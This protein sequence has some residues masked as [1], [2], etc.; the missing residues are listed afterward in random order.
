MFL[1]VLALLHAP[2]CS[3]IFLC[4]ACATVCSSVLLRAPPCSSVLL[5]APPCSSVLLRAPP[6]S[7]VFLR[8]PPCSSV[9]L[10]VSSVFPPCSSVFLRV[11]PCSSVFLRVP[12]CPAVF[13]RFRLCTS[14]KEGKSK[15]RSIMVENR[16]DTEKRMKMMRYIT[17]IT[18]Q[19]QCNH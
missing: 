3:S 15:K 7:S 16:I 6:C 1:H 19:F 12:L 11:P 9:F 4:P 18:W 2:P 5:R 10:R 8:V 17:M 13:P 14:K